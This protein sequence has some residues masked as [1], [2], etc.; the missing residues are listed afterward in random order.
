MQNLKPFHAR[1]LAEL[2]EIID[3]LVDQ[4]FLIENESSFIKL[5]ANIHWFTR[6]KNGGVFYVLLN[7][8]CMCF[9][10]LDNNINMKT[11]RLVRRTDNPSLMCDRLTVYWK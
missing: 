3:L 6:V 4:Q 10:R 1:S 9:S 8:I 5:N 7:L 11:L 2:R